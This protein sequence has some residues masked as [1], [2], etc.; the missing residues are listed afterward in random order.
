MLW[1][2]DFR[3]FEIWEFDGFV[4]FGGSG[5]FGLWIDMVEFWAELLNLGIFSMRFLLEFTDFV[6]VLF[7]LL[8]RF[9]DLVVL[10]FGALDFALVVV[11]VML[12]C[13]FWMA[14]LLDLVFWVG[15]L[16]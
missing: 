4:G 9:V 15:F 3:V 6:L 14:G 8:G 11:W 16:G 1:F 7:Y 5:R 2:W 12:L 10:R 13:L